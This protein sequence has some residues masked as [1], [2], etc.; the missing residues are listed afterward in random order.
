MKSTKDLVE[1]LLE[2]YFNVQMQLDEIVAYGTLS[3]SF[4]SG[5]NEKLT[6]VSLAS[7]RPCHCL[8]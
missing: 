4:F 3:R 5:I 1:V 8:Q 7:R 2:K 6:D